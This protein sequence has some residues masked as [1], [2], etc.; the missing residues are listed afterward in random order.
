MRHVQWEHW[1]FSA[2]ANDGVANKRQYDHAIRDF[3]RAM[4]LD[5]N[6]TSAFVARGIAYDNGK[7]QCDRAIQDFDQ[8]TIAAEQK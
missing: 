3:D 2:T 4:R 8:A 1:G 7:R 6:Y 5:P